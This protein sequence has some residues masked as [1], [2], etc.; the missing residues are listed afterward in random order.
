M[1]GTCAPAL[2]A[3]PAFFSGE[4]DDEWVFLVVS[5]NDIII[6]AS[7]GERVAKVKANVR[8]LGEA[9]YFLG[10]EL[11]RDRAA[12]TLKLGKKKLTGELLGRYG[13]TDARARSVPLGAG[14]KLTKEGEP[15]DTAK[16]PYSELVGSLL[17][18]SVCK[19][20][21]IAQAVGALARYMSAPTVAHW[22]ATLGSCAT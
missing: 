1:R 21:D 19:R 9:T 14:E 15:L 2:E 20:P 12:R 5:V 13:L 16:F 22:A 10:M 18:L 3:D 6:A 11:V 8:S 4:V 17:Y 7:E